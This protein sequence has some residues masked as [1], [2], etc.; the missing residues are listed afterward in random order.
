VADDPVRAVRLLGAATA[1][2]A[3]AGAPLPAAERG[4]VDRITAAVRR[5]LGDAA[6]T[7]AFEYSG[8]LE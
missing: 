2:R 4:D 7:A 8:D 3:S 5:T 6:F 1:L